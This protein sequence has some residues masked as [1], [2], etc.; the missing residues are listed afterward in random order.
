MREYVHTTAKKRKL[1]ALQALLEVFSTRN[2]CVQRSRGFPAGVGPPG[3]HPINRFHWSDAPFISS[4]RMHMVACVVVVVLFAGL[5][6]GNP[7]RIR[8]FPQLTCPPADVSA[9]TN[10]GC[11]ATGVDLGAPVSGGVMRFVR[12]NAPSAFPLGSTLVDWSVN[13]DA[14]WDFY[15]TQRVTVN[16]DDAPTITCPADISTTTNTGCTATG[17][18]VSSS[19]TTCRPPSPVRPTSSLQTSPVAAMRS[20]TPFAPRL[21]TTAA[22]PRSPAPLQSSL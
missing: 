3:V 21:P 22:L 11:T 20:S 9:T 7:V 1:H 18:S 15:C 13:V 5:A 12:N 19:G 14:W 4:P 8:R 6:L 2:L 17:V 16:E 10:T